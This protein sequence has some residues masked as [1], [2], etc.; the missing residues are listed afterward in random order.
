MTELS[1]SPI[2]SF[3]PVK[4]RMHVQ[5][6]ND[7]EMPW[8][9]HTLI[10]GA[11]YTLFSEIDPTFSYIMHQNRNINPFSFS[12]LRFKKHQPKGSKKGFIS[13]SAGDMATMHV[14][15]L[16]PD[17][18]R[19]IM[20]FSFQGKTMHVGKGVGK[21]IIV[22]PE[23]F[24][25]DDV[26]LKY[27]TIC[28][29]LHSTTYIRLRDKERGDYNVDLNM[30]YIISN[31]CDRVHRITGE[32]IDASDLFPYII[33]LKHH[34]NIKDS[35]AYKTNFED[36]RARPYVYTGKKGYM[37]FKI[38]GMHDVVGRLF[39][40]SEFTGVGSNTSCGFGHCSVSFK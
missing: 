23:N 39:K 1:L 19:C 17:V 28:M 10:Q 24:S 13:V 18:T 12:L 21:I 26:P 38:T 30:E 14:K 4:I 5:F 2:Y 16:H 8:K 20:Q 37:T 15:T 9:N 6:E 34:T 32:C 36:P 33:P 27:D 7:F 35:I 25:W 31:I 22:N 40:F 3:S 11:I 29:N